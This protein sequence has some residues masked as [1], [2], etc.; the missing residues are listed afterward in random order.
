[1]IVIIKMIAM[2][3]AKT[4]IKHANNMSCELLSVAKVNRAKKVVVVAI[5]RYLLEAGSKS[6]SFTTFY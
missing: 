2:N 4:F 3:C 1:M 5:V 6:V